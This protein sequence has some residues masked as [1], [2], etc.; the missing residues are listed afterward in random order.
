M[1]QRIIITIFIVFS[2]IT[3][4]MFII[5]L[6]LINRMS[7][8]SSKVGTILTGLYEAQKQN[9]GIG[10]LIYSLSIALYSRKNI[11][12]IYDRLGRDLSTNRNN[13]EFKVMGHFIEVYIAVMKHITKDSRT[14][15]QLFGRLTMKDE[16]LNTIIN[17]YLEDKN[18]DII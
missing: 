13:K 12:S 16:P 14:H 3:I 15:S 4:A 9:E 6:Y 5:I 17:D 2:V 7:A 1:D 18:N 8:N 10:N 11:L